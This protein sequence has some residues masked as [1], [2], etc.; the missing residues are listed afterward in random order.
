MQHMHNTCT[1]ARFAF[2]HGFD[3]SPFTVTLFS[4]DLTLSPGT[5][6]TGHFWGTV[7]MGCSSWCD[8]WGGNRSSSQWSTRAPPIDCNPLG[9]GGCIIRYLCRMQRCDYCCSLMMQNRVFSPMMQN[10]LVQD[11]AYLHFT[12]CTQPIYAAVCT[13]ATKND[14]SISTVTYVLRVN[15]Q[16]EGQTQHPMVNSF[17]G[18]QHSWST[19]F[20][21]NSIH[22]QQHVHGHK[23]HHD[24][25]QYKGV[26]CPK[27]GN[28]VCMQGNTNTSKGNTN[29]SKGEKTNTGKE[30][31]NMSKG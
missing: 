16:H 1:C 3:L 26:L 11:M 4:Q 15:T 17:H 2:L 12:S 18:Q 22:G 7:M 9:G 27:G 13:G 14:V 21:V 30:K 8:C 28:L 10:E 31:T 24:A 6:V 25:L 29:T 23:V 20:M 5:A 19:A